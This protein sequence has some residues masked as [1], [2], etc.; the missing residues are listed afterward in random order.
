MTDIGDFSNPE[1]YVESGDTIIKTDPSKNEVRT[2][3]EPDVSGTLII[4]RDFDS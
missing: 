1:E 4:Q 2:S 3:L